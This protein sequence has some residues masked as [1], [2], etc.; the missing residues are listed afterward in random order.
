MTGDHGLVTPSH[1][2]ATIAITTTT[3][4]S[5]I[6]GRR[7]GARSPELERNGTA[8]KMA[9]PTT[10]EINMMAVSDAGGRRLTAPKIHMKG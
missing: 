10:G 2:N 9:M 6:P 8:T 4:R 1:V 7:L 3:A 5:I